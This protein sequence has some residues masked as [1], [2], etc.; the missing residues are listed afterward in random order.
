MLARPKCFLQVKA[1]VDGRKD[2]VGHVP[3]I[4]L[5]VQSTERGLG[6][7]VCSSPYFS[8]FNS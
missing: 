2:F 1:G 5:E 7:N 6:R 8:L 4:R 3:P